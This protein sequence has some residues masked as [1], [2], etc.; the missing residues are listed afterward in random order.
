MYY[1]TNNQGEQNF[2]CIEECRAAAKAQGV[3]KFRCQN[4][5]EYFI[6]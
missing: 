3:S 4:G 5:G 2:S 1:F 6:N